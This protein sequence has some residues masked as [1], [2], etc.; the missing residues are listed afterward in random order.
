MER[1][2]HA[3]WTHGLWKKPALGFPDIT[4]LDLETGRAVVFVTAIPPI[5]TIATTHPGSFLTM[6]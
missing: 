2:R 1:V 6:I 3:P 4:D 5:A